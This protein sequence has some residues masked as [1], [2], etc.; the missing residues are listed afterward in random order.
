MFYFSHI[1][2][3]VCSACLIEC[4]LSDHNRHLKKRQIGASICLGT[5]CANGGKCVSLSTTMFSCICLTG[6]SGPTCTLTSGVT[7]APILSTCP[8]GLACLNGRHHLF[9]F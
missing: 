5:P 8:N 6:F 4:V 1:L 9:L 7:S 3:L 2:I